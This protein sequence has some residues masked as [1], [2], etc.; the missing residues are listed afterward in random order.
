MVT[1]RRKAKSKYK[2]KPLTAVDFDLDP[3]AWSKFEKLVKS[4]AKMGHKP[5]VPSEQPKARKG[6][7]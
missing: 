2:Q 6:K 7:K 5:H 1:L 4:A 3:A